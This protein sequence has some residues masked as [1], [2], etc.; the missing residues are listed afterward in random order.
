M[1]TIRL[2]GQKQERVTMTTANYEARCS[3]IHLL[4]NGRT[5]Q[6]VAASLGRSESWVYKWRARYEQ[7]G[8]AALHDQSRAPK[9]PAR[10]IPDSIKCRIREVR[11]ELEAEAHLPGKLNYIG[12]QAIRG[13]LQQEKVNPLPSISS[14]ERELRAAGMVRPHAPAE[15]P[16]VV[17]PRLRSTQ[18]H[19][20]VQVDIVPHYLPGGQCVSCFNGLD[21]VSRYPTGQ[22]FAHKRSGDAMQF[23]L[24]VW[25]ELGVPTYTQLD[26]ESC[27]SG[28]FTHPYVLGRVLRL[29][30][31]VGT[32]LVYSPFYHP[33]SNGYVERF[34]QDYNQHVWDKCFLPDLPAVQQQ[35]PAFF[36]AYRQSR[37][38]SALNGDT[39]TTLHQAQPHRRLPD[40]V[41]LPPTLPLTVGKVH[42]IR[43]VDDAYAIRVLNVDWPVPHTLPDQGVWATLEFTLTQATL[44]IFDAAPGKAQRRCLVHHPFPLKETVYPL[45]A[46]FQSPV[47]KRTF[48][49]NLMA[50]SVQWLSTMF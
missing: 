15:L 17:Y 41:Q 38:H 35:S 31:W 33:E 48:V 28:G 30:L 39:P 10:R 42:F 6:Q 16:Q 27:F 26:N 11:S 2:P 4:R 12:A 8:W 45:Q 43:R 32:Q 14:I 37:H 50:R 21:V 47:Q 22:A 5:P 13:R 36:A 18:P 20:L 1:A 34:H 7:G 3:A 25:R 19:E 44:A 23:L 40:D 29:G 46:H 24:Q 49:G 9:E